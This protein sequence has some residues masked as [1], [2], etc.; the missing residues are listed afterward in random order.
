MTESWEESSDSSNVDRISPI[1]L[2][3]KAMGKRV[4]RSK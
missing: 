4:S 3:K 2:E 1:S